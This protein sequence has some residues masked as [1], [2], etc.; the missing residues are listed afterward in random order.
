M[1]LAEAFVEYLEGVTGA[2]FGQNLFIGEAPSS[3]L[4]VD[5]VWWLTA[6]GGT[7]QTRLATGESIKNYLIEVFYR[8]RDYRSVYDAMHSL[9]EDLNCSHCIELTGF[10]TIDVS[11][12]AF[13]VDQDLDLED[14]KIGLVQA[15][16]RTH[17]GCD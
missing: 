16:I 13:P 1:N 8:D 11:A 3:N 6:S 10:E 7:P 17:K 14:R 12:T 2:V 5:S 9:E 15:T 4:V